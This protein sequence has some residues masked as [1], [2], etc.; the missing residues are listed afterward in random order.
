MSGYDICVIGSSWGGLQALDLV[1]RDLPASLPF[2]I[3]VVQHRSA[4]AP[5]SGLPHYYSGRTSLQ[6]RS[7]DDKDP[8]EPGTVY[9]APPD[10]H[11]FV[12]PGYFA[13]SLDDVVQFSRPSI[14]VLFDST[15]EAYGS[16]TIGV[17]LTGANEDG[18]A[19]LG[20]I[21]EVGGM[22]IV[23]DPATAAR[24][25]MPAGAVAAGAAKMILPLDEIGAELVRLGA[26]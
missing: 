25:T 20:R 23:Q 8:I 22:T 7:V 10:Y 18:V 1:L 5:D 4:D 17:L 15:A 26:E 9:I 16:R 21:R 3:A 12:E 14:D 19:G 2:A 6:V 13:L 11:L 24:A